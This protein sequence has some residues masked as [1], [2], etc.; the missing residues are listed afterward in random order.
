MATTNLKGKPVK[1]SGTFPTVGSK[2]AAFTLTKADLSDVTQQNFAGKA[3]IL[4]TSP[5][6]DT[7]VCAT[8]AKRFN[9]EAAGLADVEVLYVTKD[10]PFA[11]K[12]FCAAE[13][14]GRVTT[15]SD[16]RD[17][18]F[19]ERFGVQIG[20]GPMRGLMARAVFVVDKNDKIKYVELV[21]EIT[22]EPNYAAALAA[23]KA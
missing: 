14:I 13:S 8:E 23:A 12:R 2:L 10:L 19:A 4:L 9:Q 22:Q 1:L 6:F 15:L 20:E 18:G 16:L 7:G 21:P 3:K 17:S 5:S 11:Q